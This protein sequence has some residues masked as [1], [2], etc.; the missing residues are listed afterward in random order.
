MRLNNLP[1]STIIRKSKLPDNFTEKFNFYS[2][3][4]SLKFLAISPITQLARLQAEH[5]LSFTFRESKQLARSSP[6]LSLAIQ[7]FYVVTALY[8]KV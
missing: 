1:S 4:A 7:R 6:S 5:T 3:S 8:L 2:A